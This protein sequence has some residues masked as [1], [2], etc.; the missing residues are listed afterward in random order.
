MTLFE[1]QQS[2]INRLKSSYKNNRVG[3]AYI[4][5]GEKGTGK[6]EVALFF[7][8][9]LLCPNITENVPCETC[10]TC[11]RIN[12]RN[13][14]NI[15]F[16]YPDGQSIK[17]GQIDAFLAE[18]AKKGYERGHKIYIIAEAEK[19]NQASANALLKYLEEP[20]GQVTALLLT[21]SYAS[22]IPTIQ[23]RCQKI[24][25]QPP[26]REKQI[27]LLVEKGITKSM[28]AT[29]TMLTANLE[30]AIKL[31]EAEEFAHMRKTVLKLVEA[32]NQNVYEALL[33]IQSTWL[34]VFKEREDVDQGLEL[35]LFAY[36]DIVAL[37]AELNST[38]A[39]PDQVN[40]FGDWAMKMTYG[41][42]TTV[43]EAI[44]D[45]KKKLKGNMNRQLLMEQLMLNVQEGFLI[46]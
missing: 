4:L 17:K 14:P 28:A 18:M 19:M 22:I 36:R 26:S 23:S 20:E 34:Q 29:V 35:L 31:A 40:V 42:L 30:H 43:I 39:Y 6:E 27:S 7:A 38:L 25:L 44:L 41:Q 5:E 11:N 13:H 10:Q 12:T 2:V 45:A 46:V 21:E 1:E 32:L 24:S 37:K 3:H 8:K 16:I 15:I 33:Y 9:L